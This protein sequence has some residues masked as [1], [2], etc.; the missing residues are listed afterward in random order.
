MPSSGSYTI[1]AGDTRGENTGVFNLYI[2]RLNSPKNSVSITYNQTLTSSISKPGEMDSYHFS[3]NAGDK[4][5][6]R[7]SLS[8][9]NFNLGYE[10][11]NPA[12]ILECVTYGFT[13]TI[14]EADNCILS[15]TGEYL[16][17]VNDTWGTGHGNYSLYLQRLNNPIGSVAIGFGQLGLGTISNPSETQTFSLS[18]VSGDK[19]IARVGTNPNG[20]SPEFRVYSSDGSLLIKT[21]DKRTTAIASF[22]FPETS[23]Y[24]IMVGSSGFINYFNTCTGDYALYIQKLNNPLRTIPISF[25]QNITDAIRYPGQMIPYTFTAKAGTIVSVKMKEYDSGVSPEIIIY[26]S[27]GIRLCRSAGNILASIASCTLPY[28]GSYTII[29]DDLLD[30]THPGSGTGYYFLYLNWLNNPG[31]FSKSSPATGATNQLPNPTLVWTASSTAT[32]YDYCIDTSN[33]DA[34]SKWIS[35]GKSTRVTLSGLSSNTKYYW[36][37]RAHSNEGISNYYANAGTFSSFTVRPL[38]TKQYYSTSTNDGF[39]LESSELS[40][41]GG[42]VNSTAT[43]FRIGDDASKKQYRSVLSFNTGAT[44]PANAIISSVKLKLLT[45]TVFGTGNPFTT[46]QGLMVDV[47]NGYFGASASLQNSDFQAIGGTAFGPFTPS[48]SNNYYTIDLIKAKSLIN[49][50]SSSSGLTQIRLRFKLDDNN[51]ANANYISFLS[52]ENSTNKPVLV[53]TYYVP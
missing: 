15:S 12:G 40:G 25:G 16:I 1:L 43:S 53:I 20:L 23:T 17:L 22:I 6:A 11:Y 10:I 3:A 4:I 27:S 36:Q 18:A 9:S 48:P 38:I 7:L 51:N 28:T 47:K 5:L 49:R 42:T 33:N 24:Y 32:S 37:V 29:S 2:Q 14:S 26:D 31:E 45:K 50:G 34:C 13:G 30:W 39:I 21:E 41:Q 19:L 35:N 44:I 52:G 8:N 46:F